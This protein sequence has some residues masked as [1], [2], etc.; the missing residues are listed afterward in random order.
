MITR[1]RRF[2]TGRK[3]AT[4]IE[5][6]LIAAGIAVV[7]IVAVNNVG[8]ALK[9]KFE[10]VE[11]GLNGTTDSSGGGGNDTDNTSTDQSG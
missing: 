10:A 3:G 4:A 2:I 6:G 5:Y 7:I 8:G 9:G 1:I 11:N